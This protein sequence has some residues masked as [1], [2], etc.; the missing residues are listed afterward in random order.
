[1]RKITL[2]ALFWAS[3]WTGAIA[4]EPDATRPIS[5]STT[6]PELKQ[7]LD[8]QTSIFRE[9]HLAPI[10]IP[11]GEKVGDII[12][13]NNATLIA[14]VDDCFPGLKPRQ[15]S[16]QLPAITLHSEKGLAAALGASPI[17]EASGKVQAGHIFILDFEDV[18]VERV[19]LYQLRN[20]LR[21]NAQECNTVRPFLDASYSAAAPLLVKDARKRDRHHFAEADH[22]LLG[23]GKTIVADK[24]PPLLVGMLFYARRLVHVR[25]TATLD[26]D[27]KLSFGTQLLNKLGLGSTFKASVNGGDDSANTVDLVGTSLI[28]V[29]F[30][31][32]FVVTSTKQLA[33]GQVKYEVASVSQEDVEKEIRLARLSQERSF[34]EMLEKEKRNE[35]RFANSSHVDV[36]ALAFRSRPRVLSAVMD[37]THPSFATNRPKS[38]GAGRAPRPQMPIGSAATVGSGVYGVGF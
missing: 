33:S 25:T 26:G 38:V 7:I 21:N 17:A 8:T 5:S 28:P 2:F 4:Q 14:G 10:I 9:F 23:A 27:A 22:S 20:S 35:S 18:Q 30:A 16:S 6:S 36:D 15:T 34:A 24:P 13:V 29:A 32:A 3:I 37:F 11:E 1:M 12:D 19:S 31:P